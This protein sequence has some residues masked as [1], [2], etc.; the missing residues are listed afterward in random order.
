MLLGGLGFLILIYVFLLVKTDRIIEVL[1][2]DKG[3]DDSSFNLGNLTK[4][5]LAQLAILIVGLATMFHVLSDIIGFV[6]YEFNKFENEINP[7]FIG[8][9]IKFLLSA[10]LVVKNKVIATFLL[11]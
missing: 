6:H 2:L 5:T 8:A 10:V 3:F 7:Y 4:L 9:L 1:S 11:K